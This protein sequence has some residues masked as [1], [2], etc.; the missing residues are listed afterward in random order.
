MNWLYSIYILFLVAAIA[1]YLWILSRLL[2]G[3]LPE[4]ADPTKITSAL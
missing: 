1:R 2:R 3:K 4:E